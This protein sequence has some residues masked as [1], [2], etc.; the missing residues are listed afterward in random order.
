MSTFSKRMLNLALLRSSSQLGPWRSLAP[1]AP[2]WL[3]FPAAP[4]PGPV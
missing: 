1:A 4:A 3:G 2:G